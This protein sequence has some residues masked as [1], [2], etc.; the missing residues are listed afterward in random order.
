M[1]NAAGLAKWILLCLCL[2]R[3]AHARRILEE[4]RIHF[5]NAGDSVQN[6]NPGLKTY[7]HNATSKYLTHMWRTMTMH[8]NINSDS[9]VL[10][11]GQ[12]PH[13]IHKKYDENDKS[14]SLNL[15]DIGKHRQFKVNPFEN[16]CIGIYIDS[17]SESG[18]I[19][20]LIETR[21]N[22]WGLTMMVMGIIVFW[23]AKILSRNS[24]F[25]YVCGIT[26]G[27]TLSVIILI[28]L[29]GKLIPRVVILTIY[30]ITLIILDFNMI[31]D[32]IFLHIFL[33]L[34]EKLCT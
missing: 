34:R 22:V 18:Y 24:L 14:W 13:E 2:S 25:Y 7:C 10:Y 32:K 3:C 26:F 9:Y 21:I 33:S 20:T 19:M 23:C 28:Y 1:D 15:F 4:P 27:V 16:T 11:D 17:A 8:L 5:L 12:T 30:L 31:L 29:V 6:N